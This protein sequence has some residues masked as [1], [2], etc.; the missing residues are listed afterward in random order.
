MTSLLSQ[1]PKPKSIQ[2]LDEARKLFDTYKKTD[3]ATKMVAWVSSEYQ[4]MR[5]ARSMIQR[6]WSMNLAM[7]GGNQYLEVY[8][9]ATGA[10]Q[11]RV[12]KAVTGRVRS[13]VNRLRPIIRTEMARLTSQKPSAFVVPS[14]GEE[15]D[16]FAA[17]AGQQV[18]ESVYDRKKIQKLMIRNAFWMTTCGNGFMKTFWDPYATDE[19]VAAPPDM[20]GQMPVS[21]DLCFGV[22]TPFHLFVPDLLEQE[23]EDQPYVFQAYTKPLSWAKN[24]FKDRV[25]ANLSADIMASSDLYDSRYFDKESG[26]STARPDSVLII[27]AFIKP[28]GHA[29]FPNGG[30]V[31]IVG[32]ELVLYN[33]FLPYDHGQYPFTHFPHIPSGKFYGTSVL[34][35][36]NPLQKEY[37]RTRSQIVEA[38][39]KAIRGQM[40]YVDGSIDPS[41]W[42]ATAGELIPVKQGFEMPV[43]L[44]SSPIPTFVLDELE[45]IKGDMEDISG[46]HQVSRGMSPGSGVTAATAISFLQDKDDTLMSTT[47]SNVEAGMEKIAKQTLSLAVE[48][49]DMP[50]L[51]RTVGL[52]SAFD[53]VEL[54]GS[55]FDRGMDIRVEAGSALPTSRPAKQALLMDLFTNGA[56]D[57]NQLLKFLEMGGTGELMEQL[58]I[59]ERQAQRENLKMKQLTD[60]DIEAYATQLQGAFDTRQEG[61]FDPQTNTPYFNMDPNTWP[62]IVPVH[63]YDNHAVHITTHNNY[64]K[65]QEFEMLSPMIQQQFAAHIMLHQQAQYGLQMSQVQTGLPPNTGNPPP[66][67]PGSTPP[68]AP[69]MPGMGGPD[70][71]GPPPGGPEQAPPEG[72][73]P[74]G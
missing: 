61:S 46:Q 21:G 52:D 47:Y 8:G 42:T 7:F 12:P 39:N 34:D 51:V 18:W 29:D 49:W 17:N 53:A 48:Y 1:L 65:S 54:V 70:A 28:G 38:K 32:K 11:L 19:Y 74:S 69:M 31:T 41:K 2:E 30:Q 59:D 62:P 57:A 10:M 40:A 43:A 72:G 55:Q 36:L 24:F 6:Q 23:I 63:D 26:D 73:M 4:K 45:R 3:A 66:L 35:D 20:E 5:S 58:R 68:P 25:S 67:D 9:G 27:E 56:I 15:E 33:P 14:S 22:V 64:R 60:Q 16:I 50:R 44:Q 13:R 71:G 37:N